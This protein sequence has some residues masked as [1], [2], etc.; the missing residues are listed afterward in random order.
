MSAVGV[1][2]KAVSLD[3]RKVACDWLRLVLPGGVSRL[4]SSRRSSR[5]WGDQAVL[6]PRRHP[7]YTPVFLGRRPPPPPHPSHPHAAPHPHPHANPH[8]AHHSPA[9]PAPFQPF[10]TTA[11]AHQYDRVSSP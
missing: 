6:D 8:T 4:Y 2:H 7:I 3:R 9:R 10:S 5:S 1:A 11:T